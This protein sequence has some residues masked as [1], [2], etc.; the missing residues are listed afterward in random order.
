MQRLKL[1]QVGTRHIAHGEDNKPVGEIDEAHLRA[2][3]ACLPGSYT[4]TPSPAK[5]TGAFATYRFADAVQTRKQRILSQD[6]MLSELAA[7]RM[8][9]SQIAKE[10]PSLLAA[11]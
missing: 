3:V 11:Y 10:Q 5:D 4:V 1:A 8:A 6:I 2:Y 7:H 9:V